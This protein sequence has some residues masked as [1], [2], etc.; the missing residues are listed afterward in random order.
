[1]TISLE[2]GKALK[3]L[4]AAIKNMVHPRDVDTHLKNSKAAAN[5]LKSIIESS[6]S[7][8][9]EDLRE[10]MPT[11]VVVSKLIDI[12]KYVEKISESIHELSEKAHFEKANSTITSREQQQTQLLHRGIVNPINGA[13]CDHV[14]IEIDCSSEDSSCAPPTNKDEIVHMSII[15]VTKNN[16]NRLIY[17]ALYYLSYRS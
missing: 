8:A 10:I 12:I 5:E 9:I 15:L 7:L 11:L 16:V 6:S 14:A 4:A 2:S 1:M 17:V 3:D 13:N